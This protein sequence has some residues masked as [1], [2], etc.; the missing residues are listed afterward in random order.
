MGA[1]FSVHEDVHKRNQYDVNKG[2]CPG[3]Q[4]DPPQACRNDE[5]AAEGVSKLQAHAVSDDA[6]EGRAQHMRYGHNVQQPAVFR[7]PHHATM[8]AAT[9]EQQT[10]RSA[11]QQM[12]EGLHGALFSEPGPAS[13]TE[14]M[15]TH[16]AAGIAAAIAPGQAKRTAYGI[17]DYQYPSIDESMEDN[18]TE[19]SHLQFI[20]MPHGL[21]ADTDHD[22]VDHGAVAAGVH[23][24]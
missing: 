9:H 18:H 1:C 22:A 7:A 8:R 12:D 14:D 24:C 17:Q 15:R 5:A 16:T 2:P 11:G 3:L 20:D 23:A 6:V 21:T 4:P 19:D 13:C 10:L